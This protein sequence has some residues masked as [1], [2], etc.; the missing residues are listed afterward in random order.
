M[1]QDWKTGRLISMLG[2]IDS[3]VNVVLN[4]LQNERKLKKALTNLNHSLDWVCQN[5]NLELKAGDTLLLRFSSSALPRTVELKQLK[6][7]IKALK[8]VIT[9]NQNHKILKKDKKPGD[10]HASKRQIEL[11]LVCANIKSAHNLGN[12]VRSA[13][14]LGFEKIILTGYTCDY[15]NES[16]LKTS[17]GA[18]LFLEFSRF[19]TLKETMTHLKDQNYKTIGLETV[20]KPDRLVEIQESIKS[21]SK[22]A[23]IVGNETKGLP[24][25]CLSYCDFVYTV[26]IYG[27]KNSL[28]VTNAFCAAGYLILK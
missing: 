10:A 13:E 5:C 11:T 9:S 26:P 14:C 7:R 25:E 17:M 1:N 8:K 15:S 12:L 3:S 23:F 21:I 6:N 28:N 22:L 16:F 4:S 18:E 27:R 19:E 20:D 24:V 2:E